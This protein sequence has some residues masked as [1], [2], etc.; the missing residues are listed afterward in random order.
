LVCNECKHDVPDG[1]LYCSNCGLP[2]NTPLNPAPLAKPTPAVKPESRRSNSGVVLALTVALLASTLG[3]LLFRDRALVQQLQ[4]QISSSQERTVT[5]ASFSLNPSGFSS[6]KFVVP[7]GGLS[8]TVAG[9]FS[10][11]A[12]P[13]ASKA[14]R[15]AAKNDVENDGVEVLLLS[16]AAFVVWRNGYSAGSEYESG[17]VA[18]GNINAQLPAGTGI[19]YLV[20]S[21]RFSPHVAKSVHANVLLRYKSWLPESLLDLKDRFVNWLGM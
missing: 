9:E 2:T 11:D 4:D 18:Q 19:Y 10:A 8:V 14:R 17:R 5:D 7:S 6:Y 16:D 21:N 15:N 20:F 12:A 1:A 3:V 13:A